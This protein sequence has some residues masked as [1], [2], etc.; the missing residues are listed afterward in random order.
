M[1]DC[2]EREEDRDYFLGIECIRGDENAPHNS[3]D[4]LDLPGKNPII[5][6][7]VKGAR[8]CGKRSGV[9]FKDA[10]RP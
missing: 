6:N 3:P 5:L 9:A 4:C 1:C 8:Y 10:V 2:L 7:I